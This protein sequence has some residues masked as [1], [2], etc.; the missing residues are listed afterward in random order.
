MEISFN[1]IEDTN[2]RVSYL[3]AK[4]INALSILCA[5][6]YTTHAQEIIEGN[7]NEELMDYIQCDQLKKYF[8]K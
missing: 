2:D 5:G 4:C 8:L 7:F 6:I 1:K 3:R